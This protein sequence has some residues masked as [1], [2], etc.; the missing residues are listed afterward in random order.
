MSPAVREARQEEETMKNF[1]L[2][3]AGGGVT[4]GRP[5]RSYRE[6]SGRGWIALLSKESDLP[7]HGP[8]L[9][10]RY[11][12]GKD[13]I[14]EHAPIDSLERELVGGRSR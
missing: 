7:Y 3:I 9:S 6:S 11:L 12:R 2:V 1:E 8:A 4:A 14:A 10:K 5:I 13:L